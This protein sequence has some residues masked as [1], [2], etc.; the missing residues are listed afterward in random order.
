MRDE[1]VA[2]WSIL[3]ATMPLFSAVLTKG[4]LADDATRTL[5][6][7]IVAAAGGRPALPTIF[8]MKEVLNVSS[9]ME[10]KGDQRISVIELPKSWWLGKKKRVDEPAMFLVWAW[11]GQILLDPETRV[12]RIADLKEGEMDLIGLR[13]SGSV[14]PEMEIYVTKEDKKLVRIDWRSDIH[15]FSDWKR[16]EGFRYPAKCVGYKKATSKPWYFTE[17]LELEKLNSL[18][19]GLE[20]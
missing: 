1:R 3:F 6:N 4:A 15:R 11:T 20:R 18:P 5:A 9:D 10:K 17:I 7:E 13:L 8:R 12:E 14:K 16:V 19:E 2:V